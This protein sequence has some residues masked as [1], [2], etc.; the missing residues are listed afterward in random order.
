MDDVT[1]VY[2][3]KIKYWALLESSNIIEDLLNA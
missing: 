3:F 2:S 1:N